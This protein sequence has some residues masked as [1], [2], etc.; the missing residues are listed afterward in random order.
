MPI[1]EASQRE[2]IA[3]TLLRETEAWYASTSLDC[4]STSFRPFTCVVPL[5]A[6]NGH[7]YPVGKPTF[8]LRGSTFIRS[9]GELGNAM[10]TN[11]ALLRRATDA[12]IMTIANE[13]PMAKIRNHDEIVNVVLANALNEAELAET[14]KILK[15]VTKRMTANADWSSGFV[16]PCTAVVPLQNENGHS[17]E[18]GQPIIRGYMGGRY[19]QAQFIM[20]RGVV[21]STSVGWS[22]LRRATTDE[23]DGLVDA[24]P[25][26]TLVRYFNPLLDMVAAVREELSN[27]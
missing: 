10:L 16:Y 3:R 4:E 11:L 27:G 2:M 24:L 1:T 9:D 26:A 7:N 21:G 5:A 8:C 12:E 14:R 18:I 13:V 15:A 20:A 23:V 6:T 22:G 19:N 17:Y 25:V